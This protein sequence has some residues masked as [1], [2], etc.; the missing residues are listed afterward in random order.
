MVNPI[1]RPAPLRI[2]GPSVVPAT[3]EEAIL[4][5]QSSFSDTPQPVTLKQERAY[6]KVLTFGD[7]KTL[8]QH[9]NTPEVYEK[10]A[11]PLIGAMWHP[12]FLDGT[13]PLSLMLTDL[14]RRRFAIR[15]IPLGLQAFEIVAKE[16]S[17]AQSL[18]HRRYYLPETIQYKL[19]GFTNSDNIFEGEETKDIELK[20]QMARRSD[21]VPELAELLARS[22]LPDIRINVASQPSLS[23]ETRLQLATDEVEEVRVRLARV[24]KGPDEVF[25]I[26]A[27]DHNDRVRAAVSQNPAA[28]TEYRVLAGLAS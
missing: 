24:P 19:M 5:H 8:S 23:P 22:P 20:A 1:D 18:T 13:F 25:R 3:I 4:I 16:K 12:L 6:K 28:P 15:T 11:F 7:V 2:V 9:L 17:V 21:L 27:V 26:L 10:P 14:E